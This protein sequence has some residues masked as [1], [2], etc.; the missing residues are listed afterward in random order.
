VQSAGR[1]LLDAVKKAISVVV[2][3]TTKILDQDITRT[4]S[5]MTKWVQEDGNI[6]QPAK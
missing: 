4:D 6:V 2:Y 5:I 1:E 3:C